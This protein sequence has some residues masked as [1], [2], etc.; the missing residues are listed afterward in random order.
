MISNF[1]FSEKISL[2]ISCEM[3][4]RYFDTLS[5]AA[6]IGALKVIILMVLW[7]GSKIHV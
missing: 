2:D 4:K 1:Y 6:V 5:A 3:K 7:I